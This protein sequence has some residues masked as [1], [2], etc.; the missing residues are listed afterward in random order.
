MI[1][2][3]HSIYN[4]LSVENSLQL[5]QAIYIHDTCI[6]II[7]LMA[8]TVVPSVVLHYIAYHLA[9]GT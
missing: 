2:A 8:A 6:E 7:Y 5:K 1:T 9:R 4:E 3:S